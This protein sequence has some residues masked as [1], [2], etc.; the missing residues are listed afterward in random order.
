MKCLPFAVSLAS[1]A[2]VV[3]VS[4]ALAH[5]PSG[6]RPI[7]DMT[8]GDWSVD[9]VTRDLNYPWDIDRAGD[10]ILMTEAA[11]NI[12]EIE[13]GRLSRYAVETSDPI[14]Q[15]GGSGLLGM[16]LA[17][18]FQTSGLAYLYHTY[19]SASGL[20]NKVIQA[21]FDGRSW[22]ETRVLL[23]GI[24]GHRLYNGG[25]I[26]VGPDGLLYVTTGW[27]ENGRLPQDVGSLAGKVLRLTRDGRVPDDNPFKGSYVYSRG[28]RNPQGLAW[29]AAGELLVAEHGQSGRDEINL[30]K[31]GGNYGWPLVSGSEK[32]AGMEPPWLHSG[33]DTWAPSGIAFAGPEL[34]V[35]A[36]GKRGLYVVDEAAGALKPVFSSGD[37]LRDVMPVGRT[38]YVI[39]TNRSP[40][41]QGPSPDRLL[42]LSPRR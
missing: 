30:V 17:A 14:V 12:V 26:A 41:A 32:R 1:L 2:G 29:N 31:R 18:D 36:L 37:R 33:S 40:R 20:G 27:T 39:T 38:L 15:D 6:A 21:R 11:G 42:R 35:A 9:V 8:S 24:P 13:N 3:A 10:R 34:L 25:R 23:A 28:H 5:G 7:L 16:A 19:R 22:R 4:A